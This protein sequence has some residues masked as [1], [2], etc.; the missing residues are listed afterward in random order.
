MNRFPHEASEIAFGYTVICL[1]LLAG[2]GVI[3]KHT[4]GRSGPISGLIFVLFGPVIGV[5]LVVVNAIRY[6]L[7]SEAAKEAAKLN[8]FSIVAFIGMMAAC[9]LGASLI[10]SILYMYAIRDELDEW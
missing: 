4:R 10:A 2:L 7:G 5:A 3:Y 9:G 6:E 8:E 1:G